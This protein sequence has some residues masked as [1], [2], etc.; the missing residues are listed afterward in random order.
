MIFGPSDAPVPPIF[1]SGNSS[2]GKSSLI[3]DMLETLSLPHAYICCVECGS[4]KLIFESVL[5]Q[6]HG[7]R[8]CAQNN[9]SNF[10]KCLDLPS[11]IEHLQGLR[12]RSTSD[13]NGPLPLDTR[14]IVFDNAERLR[15]YDSAFFF[16]LLRLD[17]LSGINICTIFVTKV[18]R[19]HFENVL[20]TRPVLRVHFRD[21]S[22]QEA[23]E[24]LLREPL[25]LNCEHEQNIS[26]DFKT[27]HFQ[28]VRMLLDMFWRQGGGS[29]E[30]RNIAELR[31]S[32]FYPSAPLVS[33]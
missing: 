17:E 30:C 2:T 28:F 33:I 3:R 5:N 11:F 10:T 7:H 14:Y 23:Q 1:I 26:G 20:C 27:L 19:D 8:P 24:I 25:P 9:F 22:Q 4:Q 18:L 12:R 32:L 29:G 21:Y 6:L 16:S 13:I 15:L 31:F